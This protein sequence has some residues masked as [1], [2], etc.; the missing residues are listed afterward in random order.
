MNDGR[1]VCWNSFAKIIGVFNSDFLASQILPIPQR[2]A[3]HEIGV[4][5]IF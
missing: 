1:N 4:W 5:H 2:I 3:F